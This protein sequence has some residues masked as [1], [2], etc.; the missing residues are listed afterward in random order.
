MDLLFPVTDCVRKA[1]IDIVEEVYVKETT[2]SS[3]R[4]ISKG[5][6]HLTES[7]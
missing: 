5:T 7:L 4:D 6:D 3:H 2:E 1:R